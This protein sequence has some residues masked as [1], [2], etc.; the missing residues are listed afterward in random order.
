RS[1]T[2]FGYDINVHQDI[3][4]MLGMAGVLLASAIW[5][6]IAAIVAV[7]RLAR[8]RRPAAT[9]ACQF[10]ALAFAL[11]LPFVPDGFWDE[12]LLRV[13]GPG[14]AGGDLLARA[15]GQ[16]DLPRL[17]QLLAQGVAVDAENFARPYDAPALWV[18][19]REAKPEAVSFLL[20]HGA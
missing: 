2:F 7:Y 1:P 20:E 14:K 9:L 6:L 18:A 19:A 5:L 15:A 4:F 16:G 17:Q 3:P 10:L 11:G 12:A 8:G 13:A